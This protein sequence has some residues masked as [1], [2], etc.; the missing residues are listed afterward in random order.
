MFTHACDFLI[1]DSDS[2][3]KLCE[4]GATKNACQKSCV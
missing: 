2:E 1:D 3:W 4:T